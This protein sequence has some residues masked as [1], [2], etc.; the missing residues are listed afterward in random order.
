MEKGWGWPIRLLGLALLLPILYMIFCTNHPCG[1]L[2]Y[3]FQWFTMLTGYQDQH[4]SSLGEDMRKCLWTSGM[5]RNMPLNRMSYFYAARTMFMEVQS[6]YSRIWQD[7]SSYWLEQE[8]AYFLGVP[9]LQYVSTG[10][11][12][13]VVA[14]QTLGIGPGDE[15]IVPTYTWLATAAAM[16]TC[17]AIPVIADIDETLGM[18][19]QSLL[20]A[21]T[22]RTKAIIVV[23][24]RG[25]PANVLEIKKIADEKGLLLIEDCAQAFGA[26]IHGKK[27]GTFGVM[28][29]TS[30]N[31]SKIFQAGGQGGLVWVATPNEYLEERLAWAVENGVA[32]WGG[33]SLIPSYKRSFK[34][35][36]VGNQVTELPFFSNCFRS[37]SEWHASF[38]RHELT[39]LP[40]SAAWLVELK[41]AF[42]NRID[43][44]FRGV[45][46]KVQDPN[47]DRSYTVTLL[48]WSQDHVEGLSGYL[49]SQGVTADTTF[50]KGHYLPHVNSLMQKVSFHSSGFPW[51]REE[52]KTPMELAQFEV[53]NAIMWRTLTIPLSWYFTKGMMEF[54]AD[55]VNDFLAY[56]GDN[57]YCN[58]TKKVTV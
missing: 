40:E 35:K 13:L 8:A 31:P 30:V 32:A 26:S 52:D 49:E 48:L 16:T 22:N 37:P 57:D 17:G 27:V 12:A 33:L 2:G 54:A 53:S 11:A 19:P 1:R 20:K 38:L 15:V 23:H 24:M 7:A 55:K 5:V 50:W 10:T 28:G 56:A 25:V 14:A 58:L 29:I 44:R 36:A 51:T 6:R 45:L 46:Q 4:F 47:G 39:Q 42:V 18:S 3:A 43:P 34:D 9:K 41:Q 21:I